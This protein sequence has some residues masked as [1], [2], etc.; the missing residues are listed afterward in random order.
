MDQLKKNIS[1][2]LILVNRNVLDFGFRQIEIK[3]IYKIWFH[4]STSQVS[5]ATFSEVILQYF[6]NI[7]IFIF[8]RP[9]FGAYGACGHGLFSFLFFLQF[10]K[11]SLY[12]TGQHYHLRLRYHSTHTTCHSYLHQET[13][14]CL[15]GWPRSTFQSWTS[16]ITRFHLMPNISASG[17][18]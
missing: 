9:R 4:R 17:E 6:R 1:R 3:K 12:S 14:F 15:Q 16:G 13:N 18:D 2:K 5:N 8:L 10:Y 7:T 11:F